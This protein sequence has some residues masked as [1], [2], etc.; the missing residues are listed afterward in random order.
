MLTPITIWSRKSQACG[1]YIY[2][3]IPVKYSKREEKKAIILAPDSHILN[4]NLERASD[5]HKWIEHFMN[6]KYFFTVSFSFITETFF[7][8]CPNPISSFCGKCHNKLVMIWTYKKKFF[9]F[10]SKVRFSSLLNYQE[11]KKI[12]LICYHWQ[13]F[14]WH[15]R[16]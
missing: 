14:V 7:F 8:C 9:L 11:I 16:D 5:I 10:M 3:Y 13:S 6:E 15:E 1:G 4:E 2:V 12:E